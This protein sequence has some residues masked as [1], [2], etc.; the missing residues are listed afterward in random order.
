MTIKTKPATD[1]YRSNWDAIFGK[2]NIRHK[3]WCSDQNALLPP[4]IQDASK[5]HCNIVNIMKQLHD[6]QQ[7]NSAP[8]F[9]KGKVMPDV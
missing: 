8:V 4:E 9:W 7:M 1:E 5:C 3:G 2:Q 6:A